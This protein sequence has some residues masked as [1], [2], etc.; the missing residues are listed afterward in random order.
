[1]YG[2]SHTV[3]VTQLKAQ[4]LTVQ[5]VQMDDGGVVHNLR[6][7]A[8]SV[9]FRS[10]HGVHGLQRDKAMTKLGFWAAALIGSVTEMVQPSG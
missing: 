3:Q 2:W 8:S 5:G 7:V 6:F 1:M 10:V 4:E 9:L